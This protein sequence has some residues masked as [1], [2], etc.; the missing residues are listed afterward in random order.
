MIAILTF[1][2]CRI[3]IYSMQ[4]IYID[5]HTHYT[6]KHIDNMIAR[7]CVWLLAVKR[8]CKVICE[9]VVYSWKRGCNY[10]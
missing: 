7:V 5:V 9:A 2:V 1:A 6:Y 8:C 3:Y 10:W 4:E